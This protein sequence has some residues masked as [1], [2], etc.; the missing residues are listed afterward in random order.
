[1]TTWP[2]GTPKSNG[3]AFTAAPPAPVEKRTVSVRP[4]GKVANARARE[5]YA[6]RRAAQKGNV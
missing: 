6:K 5:N 1:M 3:N 2:D 4:I